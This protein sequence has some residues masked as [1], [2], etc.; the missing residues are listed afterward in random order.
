MEKHISVAARKRP[1]GILQRGETTAEVDSRNA[2]GDIEIGAETLLRWQNLPK[3]MREGFVQFHDGD[4]VHKER[5]NQKCCMG[6]RHEAAS[7]PDL[8]FLSGSRGDA[9]Y[10]HRKGNPIASGP[11]ENRGVDVFRDDE[12]RLG[13]AY[14]K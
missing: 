3:R 11:T 6:K 2:D 12:S 13:A 5:N 14:Q 9:S 8:V 10:S 1:T 7:A 4:V